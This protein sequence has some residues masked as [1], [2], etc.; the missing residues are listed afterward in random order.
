MNYS[1]VRGMFRNDWH[2][3]KVTK[4]RFNHERNARGPEP[5]RPSPGRGRPGP[6]VFPRA[7]VF[8]LYFSGNYV[9]FSTSQA[10]TKLV[11]DTRYRVH[12][13][14]QP[15]C[16]FMQRLELEYASVRAGTGS[17]KLQESFRLRM[18]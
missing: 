14:I 17:G 18:A 10:I 8:F 15:W 4:I 3:S 2:A 11:E 5:A 12:A 6:L 16:C 1:P 9:V 7:L 13:S